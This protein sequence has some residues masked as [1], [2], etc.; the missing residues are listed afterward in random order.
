VGSLTPTFVPARLVGLAVKHPCTFALTSRLPSGLRVPLNASVTLWEATAPVKL[1]TSH[2]P[3]QRGRLEP[4]YIKSGI[5]PSPP[6]PPQGQLQRVPPILRMMKSDP[7]A[8]CSKAP[9]GLFVLLWVTRIFTGLSISPGPSS[10]QRSDRYAFR[11]GRNLPDKEFR[12]LRTVIVTAAVYWGFGSTLAHLP[13]T[14]QHWAGIS[15]YTCACAFAK[16]YGFVNQSP[17][18]FLCDPQQLPQ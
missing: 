17:E 10:R 9:R 11:A 12:Y 8:S 18:P 15:P 14:F 1:P 5:S 13:L 2:C 3:P 7:M 4:R 6:P 16:T